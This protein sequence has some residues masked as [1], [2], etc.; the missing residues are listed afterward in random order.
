[1]DL[2][3]RQGKLKNSMYKYMEKFFDEE[4]DKF[5]VSKD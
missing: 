1:M 4:D 2:K 5:G 3:L